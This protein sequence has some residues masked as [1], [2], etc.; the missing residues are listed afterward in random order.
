MFVFADASTKAYGAVVYLSSSGHVSL[1]MSN[2]RVAPIKTTS[3]P[4]LELMAAVTAARLA[5]FVHSSITPEQPI[6]QVHFWT[7]SQIVLHWIHK[8]N[9]PKPL[10]AYRIQEICETFPAAHW[11]FT[12]SAEN[13]ADLLTRGLS[14]NQL[15]MSHLWTH[16]PHWLLT[17]SDWPTWTPT[18]VLC[19]QAE[20]GT[21]SGPTHCTKESTESHNSI[22]S[23]I[24]ISRYSCIHQL[25][26][27]TFYV[28]R[29][30][31]N[32]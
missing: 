17:Q 28:L 2:T 20:E 26:T 19:L 23:L 8:G 31:H 13:P 10:I 9:N 16:G 14:T 4:R 21:E 3:L 1:A 24:D 22:L 25:L 6:V 7:D 30:I 27:I 15:R 11:S 5:K 12:P 18:P 32:L 29:S